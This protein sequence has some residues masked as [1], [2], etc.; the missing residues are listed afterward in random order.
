MFKSILVNFNDAASSLALP[1]P[2]QVPALSS[3]ADTSRLL[4]QMLTQELGRLARTRLPGLGSRSGTAASQ[5]E[6]EL[7]WFLPLSFLVERRFRVM[8]EI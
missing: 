3:A 6:E 2:A 7:W 1:D 5:V 8:G 4:T